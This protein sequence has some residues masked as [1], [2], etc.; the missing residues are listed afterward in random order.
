MK[1]TVVDINEEFS[2][3]QIFAKQLLFYHDECTW[4][5]DPKDA[6]RAHD[7]IERCFQN[8]PKKYGVEIMEAGDIKTGNNYME[9][10]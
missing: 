5:I 6:P 8:S 4:E 10:H 1:A 7:I 2:R 9:V 3:C